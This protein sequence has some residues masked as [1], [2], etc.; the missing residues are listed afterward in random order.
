MPLF[1]IVAR[2]F[3]PSAFGGYAAHVPLGDWRPSRIVLHNTAVPCLGDRPNGLSEANVRDL[4]HYYAE[5]RGW[6]GGPHLFVDQTGVWVFN[7]LDRRGVHSPSWNATSWGVE[8]LGDFAAEPFGT[9]DGLKVAENA[10]AA[11]AALFRRL[12]VSTVSDANLKLHKEDPKT[13]HDCPGRNV[14]K[15]KVKEAV[16]SRLSAPPPGGV[17]WP[18]KIVVYRKG[19]GQSPSAVLDAVLRNGT[20][21]ADAGDLKRAMGGVG[22]AKGEVSVRA[23]VDGRFSVAWRPETSRVYLSERESENG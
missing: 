6:S 20:V 10:A 16:Q 11:L 15:L 2:K 19:A 17:G 14:D 21:Y 5:V 18:A 1:P 22:E 4:A 8:M 13:T 9:G 3:T 12:G 23:F 7:P